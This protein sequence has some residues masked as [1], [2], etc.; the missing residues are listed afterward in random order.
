MAAKKGQNLRVFLD[1]KC[2]AVSTSCSFHVAVKTEDASTKDSEGD[3]DV[4]EVTGKSWDVSC[5]TLYDPEDTTGGTRY[6]TP[7][8]LMAKIITTPEP[9]VT[10]M[11]A[12][13]DGEKNRISHEEYGYKGQAILSDGNVTSP[14]R[15][16]NTATFQF[17]GSGPLEP[18]EQ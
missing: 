2:I 6:T 1:E 16:K 7:A 4:F 18:A 10:V 5:D 9:I 13:A 11:W 3:F 15:Q 12:P 17:T 8:E 14:N